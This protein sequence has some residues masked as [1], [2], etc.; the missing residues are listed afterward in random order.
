MVVVGKARAAGNP[1]LTLHH[2]TAADAAANRRRR[3]RRR[4]RRRHG[5]CYRRLPPPLVRGLDWDGMIP[6]EA[7]A[8]GWTRDEVWLYVG[9]SG[10]IRPR[11]SKVN[12]V[13]E[14]CHHFHDSH[15]SLRLLIRLA[16]SKPC[17]FLA[18]AY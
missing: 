16:H 3:R 9:S 8:E 12:G 5:C 2:H 7:E 17:C 15:D 1:N 4:C 13:G 14:Y 6:T 18:P 11:K 10:Y